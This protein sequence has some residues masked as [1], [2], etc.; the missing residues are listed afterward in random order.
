M[1]C[2]ERPWYRYRYPT[3]RAGGAIDVSI[4]IVVR[5]GPSGQ[6]WTERFAVRPRKGNLWCRFRWHPQRIPNGQN[7]Q[8]H[9]CRFIVNAS[10][11]RCQSR[12]L[13]HVSNVYNWPKI[14]TPLSSVHLHLCV[15]HL[16]AGTELLMSFLEPSEKEWA[17]WSAKPNAH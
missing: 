11:S 2:W 6:H 10:K 17:C 4:L 9:R 15:C 7:R 12:C 16:D 5:G 8:T 1:C 13:R 14:Q 3:S